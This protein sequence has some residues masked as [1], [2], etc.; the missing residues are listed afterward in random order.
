[1]WKETI[2]KDE[3][4]LTVTW[5]GRGNLE[6]SVTSVGSLR[7]DTEIIEILRTLMLSKVVCQKKPGLN[8][9]E[10]SRPVAQLQVKYDEAYERTIP[11]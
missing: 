6:H 11:Q 2:I 1:M 10:A 3:E 7:P 8:R 9:A 4:K 5:I